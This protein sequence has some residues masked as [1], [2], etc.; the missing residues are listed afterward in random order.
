MIKVLVVEDEAG[1]KE[2]LM[3][4]FESVGYKTLGAS[5]AKE[6][7]KVF[8]EE[9]PDVIF[10]D[11]AL[12]DKSGLEVLEEMKSIE[13][14]NIVIMVSANSDQAVKQKALKLGAVEFITKPFFRETLR[15]ALAHNLGKLQKASFKEKPKILI[16]DDEEDVCMALN[17]YLQ[18]HIDADIVIAFD[19][20]QAYDLIIK[21]NFDVVF[22]DIKLQ[23][24]DGLTIIAQAKPKVPQTTFLVLTGYLGTEFLQQAKKIGVTE[25]FHK[26]VRPEE[27]YKKLA[28]ILTA[29]NKYIEKK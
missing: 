16:V 14:N 8:H 15:N 5:S 19:G 27:I 20:D 23:G 2:V 26:P 24:K 22:M 17:R 1:I 12:P 25:Y 11:I 9:Q 29:K 13:K 18:K 7:M 4:T 21:N 28:A 10:L 6:A 3:N